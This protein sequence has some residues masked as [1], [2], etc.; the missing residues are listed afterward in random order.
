MNKA[1]KWLINI[2]FVSS[3]VA[4]VLAIIWFVTNLL[5]IQLRFDWPFRVKGV[6][7]EKFKLYI[8]SILGNN[9]SYWDALAFV[10][11]H[12]LLFVGL[13][14]ITGAI[15]KWYKDGTLPDKIFWWVIF[16]IAII[17]VVFSGKLFF[18]GSFSGHHSSPRTHY[19][20]GTWVDGETPHY[21]EG[22]WVNKDK[23]L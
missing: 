12:I 16:P 13:V 5:G 10:I 14:W 18:G 17:Y 9:I 15:W 23:F 11:I 1:K 6:L 3:L 8:E 21:R 7:L 20:R 4:L 22:T 19:R 2:W